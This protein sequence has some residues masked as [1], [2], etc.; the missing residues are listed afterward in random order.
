MICQCMQQ[1][2][3]QMDQPNNSHNSSRNIIDDTSTIT[4]TSTPSAVAAAHLTPAGVIAALQYLLIYLQDSTISSSSSS[5]DTSLLTD[6]GHII[7]SKK[8]SSSNSSKKSSSYAVSMSERM[9]MSG[10]AL[11]WIHSSGLDAVLCTILSPMVSLAHKHTHVTL[12]CFALSL[13][14]LFCLAFDLY[15]RILCFHICFFVYIR[16]LKLIS[17][18]LLVYLFVA[19]LFLT[20]F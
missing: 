15:S 4:S 8:N 19:C 12:L 7:K 17:I 1:S 3:K 16:S 2:S 11:E 5:A 10:Q 20:A 13:L 18:T 6:T 9:S 14:S